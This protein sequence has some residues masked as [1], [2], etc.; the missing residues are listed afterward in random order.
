MENNENNDAVRD[1]EWLVSGGLI[2]KLQDGFN[3]EEINVTMARGSR[4][5]EKRHEV[6]LNVQS[7]LTTHAAQSEAIASQAMRVGQLERALIDARAELEAWSIEDNGERY[8]NPAM[9]AII[10]GSQPA[11]QPGDAAPMVAPFTVIELGHGKVEIGDSLHEGR[12]PAL[13]FG[14]NGQ[15]MGFERVRNNYAADGETLAVVT[16]E[17]VEGLD[18][19][20]EVIQRIRR[21]S[22]PAAQ[23]STDLHAAIMNL[24]CDTTGMDATHALSCKLGHRAARHAAAELVAAADGDAIAAAPTPDAQPIGETS[25]PTRLD[26]MSLIHSQMHRVY[27]SAIDGED[28]D[29]RHMTEIEDAIMSIYH[30]RYIAGYDL[31]KSEDAIAAARPSAEADTLRAWLSK[32]EDE[33][34][35][36]TGPQVFTKVRGYLQASG[37][38]AASPAPDRSAT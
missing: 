7:M 10:D 19:L 16:F 15:G 2:Y 29:T 25:A 38:L 37:Y 32:L 34:H 8:N 5:T 21:I 22:F 18:V 9:N 26:V 20:I 23:P 31:R 11:Q 36:N 33:A 24:R 4:D 27:A 13:W 1:G 28:L 17:N 14:K 30:G 3:C 6:A 35:N 12:L